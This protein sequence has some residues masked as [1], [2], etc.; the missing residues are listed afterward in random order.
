MPSEEAPEAQILG[1]MSVQVK[2][3][4]SEIGDRRD[5]FRWLSAD[6]IA[7]SVILL[8]MFTLTEERERSV[9]PRP[10]PNLEY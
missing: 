4:D 7:F 2:P 6:G 1:R 9:C 5:C 10:P 3:L 8:P